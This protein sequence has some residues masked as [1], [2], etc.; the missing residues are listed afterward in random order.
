MTLIGGSVEWL[1]VG[2]LQPETRLMKVLHYIQARQGAEVRR[3]RGYKACWASIEGACSAVV[4]K[5]D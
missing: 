2:Q 5:R 3:V 1:S 4:V